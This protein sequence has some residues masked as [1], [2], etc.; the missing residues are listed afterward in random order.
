MTTSRQWIDMVRHG[1][2]LPPVSVGEPHWYLTIIDRGCV[3][4]GRGQDTRVRVSGKPPTDPRDRYLDD[5]ADYA[6]G[7]HFA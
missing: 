3:L 6:C 2:Q 7:S 1:Q 5:G 4:C